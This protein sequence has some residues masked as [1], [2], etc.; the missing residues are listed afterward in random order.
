MPMAVLSEM[1]ADWESRASRKIY[2]KLSVTVPSVND[3]LVP[4]LKRAEPRDKLHAEWAKQL[5]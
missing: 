2:G 3:L 1:P 5:Q 4:K